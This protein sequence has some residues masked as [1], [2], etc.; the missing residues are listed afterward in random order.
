MTAVML[1]TKAAATDDVR[2]VLDAALRDQDDALR[3]A[4]AKALSAAGLSPQ[5]MLQTV[6]KEG[7][8]SK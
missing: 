6:M 1:R 2:A 8:G 3:A 4:A 7:L 5:D